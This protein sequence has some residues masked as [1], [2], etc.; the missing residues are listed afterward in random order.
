M[1]L[2]DK[3]FELFE[4]NLYKVSKA[5]HEDTFQKSARAVLSQMTGMS[6][7]LDINENVLNYIQTWTQSRRSES[8][9]STSG[10]DE[11]TVTSTTK[12]SNDFLDSLLN[13]LDE[14]SPPL[15]DE[16]I[17]AC[18]LDMIMHGSE[19]LKGALSWLL[20]YV[21][22]YPD[23]AS[24]C[25]SEARSV[26]N[27]HP[28]FLTVDVHF[29]RAQSYSTFKLASAE[30]LVQTQAFVKEVLRLSPVVPIVIHSTLQDFK[31]RN[32]HIQKRTQFGA[33]IVAL[34][35]SAA[36]KE[37]SKFNVSRWLGENAST[38][39]T[40]S[41][42]PFGFGP[43]ACVAEKYLFNLLTGVLGVLLYHNDFDKTSPLPEP[44]E[45]TFGL[46]NM[47]K[48]FSLKATPL[49]ARS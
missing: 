39:P 33:N 49:S 46:A 24:A 20:L 9:R 11:Q 6:E 37:A 3:T 22:K 12:T 16:D 45:G 23:D 14:A 31:W 26:T 13:V 32:F 17:A 35:N 29:S 4:Q 28:R 30:S 43:R 40:H 8:N 7:T 42:S 19:M 48:K 2:D 34:H 27:A 38:I 15:D 5:I 10:T 18:V 41:Y 44:N 47:P 25:R 36:W 1:S 21:V